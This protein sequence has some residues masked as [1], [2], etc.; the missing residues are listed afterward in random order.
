MYPWPTGNFDY[1]IVMD[2]SLDIALHYLDG[3]G[4]AVRF[5]DVLSAAAAI[6]AAWER[7]V[8][9]RIKLADI[10]IKTVRRKA[11]PLLKQPN[12]AERSPDLAQALAL[13]R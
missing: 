10:A 8:R 12:R 5:Q 9:H 4:H 1:I 7:G 6:V 2:D 11:E 3:S 13:Q